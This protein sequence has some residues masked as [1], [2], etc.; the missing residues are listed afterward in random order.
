MALAP[1]AAIVASVLV[2][3][4][5]AFQLALALG[6]PYGDAVFGGKAP[7]D[8]GVLTP[9][10]RALAVVQA[11][12]LVLLAWVLLA[13][14][15]LMAMP[16]LSAATLG[17]MTWA[18]LGFLVLNTAANLTAPHPIERWGMGST[19]L[20]LSALTLIIAVTG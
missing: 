1:I 8:A 4:V 10:F 14:V 17:W 13:R 18:I 12:V 9:P 7:T 19:T 6:A 11:L 20:V 3:G 5:A 2:A 16:L 15:E